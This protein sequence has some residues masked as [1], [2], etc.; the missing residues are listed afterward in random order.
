LACCADDGDAGVVG[1]AGALS[2]GMTFDAREVD[3]V[4][5]GVDELEA[6]DA[7]DE[8]L[9]LVCPPPGLTFNE[10]VFLTVAVGSPQVAGTFSSH[11]F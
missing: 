4:M 1:V 7:F 10:S 3:V 11:L 8:A 5:D 2:S 9:V 6:S